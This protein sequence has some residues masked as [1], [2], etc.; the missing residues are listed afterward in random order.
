[1]LRIATWNL[2]PQVGN[3]A[4]WDYLSRF[5]NVDIG[6]CQEAS[7]TLPNLLHHTKRR[8]KP[9]SHDRGIAF[10]VFRSGVSLRLVG[11]Y[12]GNDVVAAEIPEIHNLLLI[13]VHCIRGLRPN[14]QHEQ[15]STA[16]LDRCIPAIQELLERGQPTIVAG[17]FNTSIDLAY[18]RSS[19]RAVFR[20]LRQLGLKDLLCG[21]QC[22]IDHEGQCVSGHARTL[23]RGNAQWR[24]DHIY[25]TESAAERCTSAFVDESDEAWRLSDHRPIIAEFTF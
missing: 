11:R 10:A 12:A 2:S 14:G 20:R 15:D 4:K 6:I 23:K 21:A 16:M 17:D 24:I 13:A 9:T 8:H 1:M 25:A 19:M 18:Q 5:L 7:A 3:N 22:E